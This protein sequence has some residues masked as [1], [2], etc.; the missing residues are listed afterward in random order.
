MKDDEGVVQLWLVS[1]NGGEPRQLTF[2]EGGFSQHSVGTHKDTVWHLYV[3][4]V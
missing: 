3:I 4:T 1:P 2:T